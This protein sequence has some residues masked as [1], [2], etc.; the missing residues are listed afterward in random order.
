MTTAE[1]YSEAL[2]LYKT[3]AMSITE[4]SNR[5]GVSRKAFAVYIQRN[6][7]DL[8][9]R[10]HGMESTA[11][12]K[13]MRSAKGQTPASRRKY[14]DAI[15]ACDSM[16]YISLNISQI[17]GLFNL[18][19]T[20]L[21]NQLRAHYPEILERREKERRRTGIA[22]SYPR[23]PRAL[24]VETYAA[25]LEMLRETDMTIGEVA[26]ACDV[27]FTGL[28]QHLLHYH[29][30]IVADR[31]QRRAEGMR[32]PRTGKMSGNGSVRQPSDDDCRRYAR[33]V[34]LYRTTDLSVA[35][36]C[37]LS[38]HS[39][40]AFKNHMRKWHKN[41]MF[42]RRGASIPPG[43]SDRASL[44]GVRRFVPAVAEKYAPAVAALT[45][46]ARSVGEIAREF[47]FVPEVFREYLRVHY[48][49]LWR[50]MGMTKLADGRNVLR[51]SKEKYAEAIEIYRTS[52]ESL[53]SIARRLDLNYKS[54]GG[55]LRRNMPEII[56]EHKRLLSGQK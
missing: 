22:D 55:F 10:R 15:V 9:Y 8:M 26:D 23:G 1:K 32:V 13:K 36:I 16:E 18:D 41:L 29:K 51:R 31:E 21:A 24:A 6:H 3:T 19:G 4:I 35:E 46:G 44:E 33:A 37:S 39:T 40:E 42:G 56:E 45:A 2:D 11:A 54:V 12:E 52:K 38:G 14:H 53:M 7:R 25:A 30:D 28:R 20:A 47:G 43:G 34:E 27:S 48:P 17:A 50:K 49:A 5:C